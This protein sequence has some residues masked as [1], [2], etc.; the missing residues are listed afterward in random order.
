MTSNNFI[1][2]LFVGVRSRILRLKYST[3]RDERCGPLARPAGQSEREAKHKALR[4]PQANRLRLR[5]YQPEGVLQ[6]LRPGGGRGRPK[7][8][9]RVRGLSHLLG[10][11]WGQTWSLTSMKPVTPVATRSCAG[12]LPSACVSNHI[13]GREARNTSHS[14]GHRHPATGLE[15]RPQ[16]QF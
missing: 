11:F 8:K 1:R 12:A 16:F 15:V 9:Q 2:R 10:H 14:G 3:P 13:P 6:D 4:A 5:P 7:S